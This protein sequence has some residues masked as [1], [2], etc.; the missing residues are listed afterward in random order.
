MRHSLG[1]R[2]PGLTNQSHIHL[3]KSH[4]TP[5][6]ELLSYRLTQAFLNTP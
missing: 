4:A 6:F 1:R 3:V 5:W 2:I